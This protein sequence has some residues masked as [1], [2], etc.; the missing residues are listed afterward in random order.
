MSGAGTLTTPDLPSS[1]AP[2]NGSAPVTP[3]RQLSLAAAL[4]GPAAGWFGGYLAVF[5]D[6]PLRL[7]LAFGLLGALPLLYL[8]V[9][10]SG[11]LFLG[12]LWTRASDVAIWQHGLP[13]I[14]LPSGLLLLLFSL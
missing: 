1:P 5:A 2:R 14:A 7:A 10:V 4:G 8:Y 11:L 12:L 3:A 9:Q 13:S 6:S